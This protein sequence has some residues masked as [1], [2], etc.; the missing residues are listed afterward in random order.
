MFP[1]AIGACEATLVIR[2]PRFQ[3]RIADFLIL[4]DFAF[5]PDADVFF[6]VPWF[7]VAFA[8]KYT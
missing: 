5:G 4:D 7:V 6:A 1:L 8:T 2:V 3:A